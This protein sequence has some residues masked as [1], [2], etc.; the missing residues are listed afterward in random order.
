M[1]TSWFGTEEAAHMS[2]TDVDTVSIDVYRLFTF[3]V[4]ILPGWLS[5]QWLERHEY[6]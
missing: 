2:T 3:R 6:L 5:F 4:P 1:G